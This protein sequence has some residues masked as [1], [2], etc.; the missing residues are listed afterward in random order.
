L[1]VLLLHLSLPSAGEHARQ[2]RID[3]LAQVSAPAILAPPNHLQSQSQRPRLPAPR[4]LQAPLR[5]TTSTASFASSSFSCNQRV[6]GQCCAATLAVTSPSATLRTY[7]PATT[8]YTRG[9]VAA[10]CSCTSKALSRAR[11]VR[12]VL[13]SLPSPDTT[14]FHTAATQGCRPPASA[15]GQLA[16]GHLWLGA[17]PP[18]CGAWVWHPLAACPYHRR[19][20]SRLNR[21]SAVPLLCAGLRRRRRTPW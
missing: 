20:L 6:A 5:S 14:Y 19:S 17:Q 8:L 13:R 4:S 11:H 9:Q 15:R 10:P 1:F 12:A 21:P 2:G 18:P 3:A 7:S 16:T